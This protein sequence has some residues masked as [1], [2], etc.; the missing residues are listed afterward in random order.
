MATRVTRP[1]ILTAELLSALDLSAVVGVSTLRSGQ[2]YYREGRAKVI[3]CD[4]PDAILKVRGSQM[5]PYTVTGEALDNGFVTFECDCPAFRGDSPCK[6]VVASVYALRDYLQRNPPMNWEAAL[7]GALR[8]NGTG[9]KRTRANAP[10]SS[11]LV[12]SLQKRGARWSAYLYGL[13]V[14]RFPAEAYTPEP[15]RA[16]IT[17]TIKNE[18][19]SE[20]TSVVRTFHPERFV[21]LTSGVTLAARMATVIQSAGGY[22]GGYYSSAPGGLEQVL[23][24]LSEAV[25]YV[26]TEQSPFKT[27][28]QIY[29][30]P[31]E[32][33]LDLSEGDDGLAIS[34][35]LLVTGKSI[36]LEGREVIHLTEQPLW[37]LVG[38]DI[39]CLDNAPGP[40]LALASR[41]KIVVPKGERELFFERYLI[42]LAEQMPVRGD[43]VRT[44]EAEAVPLQ[45]R[46]YLSE[47]AA[48]PGAGAIKAQLRFGYGG[49]EFPYTGERIEYALYYDG[50]G[51]AL[52]KVARVPDAEQKAYDDL[53]NYLLKRDVQTGWF[54]LRAKTDPVDFLLRQV[55]RLAEAGYEVYGEEALVSVRVN[56]KP[57]TMKLSVSSGID[58]FDLDAVVQFG[59]VEAALKDIRRAIRRRERYV[60]LADGSIGLI[61]EEWIDRYRLLFGFA[62]E[63]ADGVRLSR[64]HALLIEETMALADS[65]EADAEFQRRKDR[66]RGF[67]S[68]APRPLPDGLNATL[69]PYQKA[70]YDWL[71]FLHDY[72][73]G[74]CLADDMGLG[75]TITCLSYLLSLRNGQGGDEQ[76]GGEAHA[77]APDLV[78]VPRSLVFNWQREAARFTPSLK[79]LVWDGATRSKDLTQFDGYDIVL[80]TYRLMLNEI[81]TLRGYRFHHAILDEAQA[82][83]NPSSQTARAARLLNAEHRLTLTGTPVENASH[84]LWSQFEFLCPGMLGSFEQFRE[85]FGLAIEKEGDEEAAR[86]LRRLIAPFLLRRTKEQVAPELPPRTEEVRVIE[87]EPGQRK[88]YNKVRDQYRADILGLLD[89]SGG[90]NMS[91]QTQM[92]VLEALLRLRQYACHPK[93][94]EK[95]F[96]GDSGKFGAVVEMME[97]L[98]SEG[99]KAL[100][101]S[102]FTTLLGLLREELDAR[103]LPYVYLDGRTRDRQARVDKFQSDASVPFFLISLKAG[104]FGLN[105]TAADYVIHV[106]PWWNPAAEQQATDRAHRIGQ[107]KPVF[108]YKY[109]ARDTVEE[110][111]LELQERKRALANQLITT[112]GG[113]LKALSRKDI[114][115]LFD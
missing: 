23:P 51:G 109:I 112:E 68:I 81:E 113:M 53:S 96:K 49:E 50:E 115:A 105:L 47:D 69:Y 93:L 21:G 75:K 3:L 64:Q 100:V 17:R 6:H 59:E 43:A 101:F 98:Q 66:L 86:A 99:H 9:Q 22:Y 65:A 36:P 28:V 10:G 82:I 110:K 20:R 38:R 12:F 108:V 19:F 114:E 62:E 83:K 67:E 13:P 18:S 61:P 60:K 74:G 5:L 15:N 1:T 85:Q 97:T 103:R 79:I 39:F 80:T 58:W 92:R 73:F 52:R 57:P 63:N 40:F 27:P 77:K 48:A 41:D 30:E 44:E 24:L 46:L 94:V 45:P 32:A 76:S 2:Q 31:L 84:E 102:Q 35:V 4:G 34:P 37:L 107:D 104:G 25:V 33:A 16:L 26:G 95:D 42:P 8:Q 78:V 71:H 89:E 14:A 90:E 55:P 11:L 72:E 29:P 106:D 7:S 111:I 56:R 88:A 91:G 54:V 87:M 70:G